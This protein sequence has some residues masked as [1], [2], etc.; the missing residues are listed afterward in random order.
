MEN[1]IED[2]GSYENVQHR[3]AS[4][5]HEFYIL[6]KAQNIGI[7]DLVQS[8]ENLNIIVE[9]A[10]SALANK[11]FIEFISL[12]IQYLEYYLK[13]YWVSKNPNNEVLDENSRKFFGT[14]INECKSYGFDAT[15]ISKVE[16][17][18]SSRVD[19]IHKFLMGGTSESE[20]DTI[21]NQYSKL[22]NEVKD[23]VIKDCGDFIEDVSKIPQEVGTMIF[24]RPKSS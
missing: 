2:M 5:G 22:G 3:I 11:F 6:P 24:T 18:N 16:D 20:L 21:C 1:R 13:I 12:K 15:I 9:R 14:L 23:F 7:T 17:F 10:K 19:A 8:M 4:D